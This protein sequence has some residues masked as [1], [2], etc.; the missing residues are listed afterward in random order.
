M[1]KTNLFI[2]GAPKAGT[3]FLYQ[4]LQGHPELFFPKIKEVNFFSIEDL[5]THNSYYKDYRIEKK[6]TYLNFYKKG[7][8]YKY[9]IDSSVSYFAFPK[10]PKRIKAFNP[11]AKFIF[12]LRNPI[13]RAFSHYKMDK[14][15]GYASL[16]FLD[17]LDNHKYPE[18]YRQ[19]VENSLYARNISNY[20]NIFGKNQICV[21]ILENIEKDII[22]LYEFLNIS[23][24][25]LSFDSSDKVNA[26]KKPK[27][28]ISK[29]LQKN[30]RLT[31]QLKMIIP[32]SIVNKFNG[33]LYKEEEKEEMTVKERSILNDLLKED[34]QNLEQLLK[35]D[36]H[37]LWKINTL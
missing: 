16:P 18:H 27:N 37:T 14:R 13:Q 22:K 8:N 23:G 5:N 6:S 4:K 1:I 7:Q 12:I 3:S 10:V 31:S 2:A 20:I 11:D 25:M 26:N 30:R 15:M 34:R 21:L 24:E 33:L 29:T 28:I 17:Y 19:Y 32:R 35:L 9:L 36:I